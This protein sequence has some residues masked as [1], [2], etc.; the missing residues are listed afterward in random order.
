MPELKSNRINQTLPRFHVKPHG[1]TRFGL[2]CSIQS[3]D[4]SDEKNVF[5]SRKASEEVLWCWAEHSL[6]V[7]AAGDFGQIIVPSSFSFLTY[8]EGD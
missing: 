3:L 7:G 1:R 6:G 2:S 8:G 4:V 5:G